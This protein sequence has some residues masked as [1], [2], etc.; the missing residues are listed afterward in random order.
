MN[1]VVFNTT[2]VVAETTGGAGPM[3]RG[4]WRNTPVVCKTAQGVLKTTG[5]VWRAERA[6]FKRSGRKP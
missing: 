6:G 1:R 3:P 4:L 5:S 2:W